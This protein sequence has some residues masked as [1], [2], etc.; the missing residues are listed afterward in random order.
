MYIKSALT[1]HG[2]TIFGK[3]ID[4]P[5]KLAKTM[6]TVMIKCLFG[7]P[8]FIYKAY[9][10]SNLTAQ[11]L[12]NEATNI[13]RKVESESAIKVLA[14][15][16][17][18]HRINQKCFKMLNPDSDTNCKPWLIKSSSQFL[19]YEYVHVVKCIR[20]V[21]KSSVPSST[22]CSTTPKNVTYNPQL[23]TAK[24]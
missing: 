2:G 16:A 20:A 3:S 5:E 6:L 1:Y 14:I 15:I 12:H 8:E 18:G 4:C 24:M 17:D 23:A 22:R 19:F 7:G 10:M 13:A 21:F 9:P 11:F